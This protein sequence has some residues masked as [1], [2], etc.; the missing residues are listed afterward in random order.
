M[1]GCLIPLDDLRHR[2]AATLPVITAELA[3]DRD[4]VHRLPGFPVDPA[5]LDDDLTATGCAF[6]S[7]DE[8]GF[9]VTLGSATLTNCTVTGNTSHGCS[10]VQGGLILADT[11][12]SGNS[13]SEYGG[14]VKVKGLTAHGIL[15]ITGSTLV[16]GNTAPVGAGIATVNSLVGGASTASVYGNTGADQCAT[17]YDEATR[18][19]VATCVF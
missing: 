10:T 12:V 9:S 1:S 19:T 6:S 4:P 8:E 2:T 11:T 18:T 14:G 16:T 7:I 3:A 5:S 17:S 13:H 15:S